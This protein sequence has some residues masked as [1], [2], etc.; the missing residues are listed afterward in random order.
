M[1]GTAGAFFRAAL[2]QQL[3]YGVANG[4]GLFTNA[5]FL[6][7][8]AYAIEA[9]YTHRAEIGGMDVA[10]AVGFVTLTQAILMVV[11]QWGAVGVAAEVYS[12]Q[13]AVSLLRP[14]D[15]F[16]AYLARRFGISAYYVGMRMLP[17]LAVGAAAG[18]LPA[19][20]PLGLLAFAASL[21]LGA[22][23]ANT[24][25]FLVELSSFWLES[26]RGVRHLV[27]SAMVLPSG[28][29]LPIAFFPPAVQTL[30]RATPFPY[31]LALPAELWLGQVGRAE[32]AT[33]LGVQL[34]WAIALTVLARWGFARAT[35][36]LVLVGG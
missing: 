29:L 19:P 35:R 14:V 4:A 26:E 15:F 11:P 28:L 10:Q 7:F 12:G 3:A 33:A 17:L 2:Q 22:W 30:F 9:L 34:G 16:G 31:S 8:R 27:L 25:L 32:A 23:I 36:R 24:L 1:L 13:I 20:R 5:A 6:F 21:G 18:L